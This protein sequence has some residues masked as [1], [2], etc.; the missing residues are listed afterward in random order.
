MGFYGNIT[1]TTRTQFQFDRIYPNRQAMDQM[2]SGDGVY[3]G[4]FVLI[5]YD[6]EESFM[7]PIYLYDGVPYN[8]IP[9]NE[10]EDKFNAGTKIKIYDTPSDTERCIVVDREKFNIKDGDDPTHILYSD[11]AV[12]VPAGMRI[13]SQNQTARYLRFTDSDFIGYENSEVIKYV[14]TLDLIKSYLLEKGEVTEE[15]WPEAELEWKERLRIYLLNGKVVFNNLEIFNIA[16][17]DPEFPLNDVVWEIQAG[18]EYTTNQYNIYYK[19][20]VNANEVTENGTYE[21]FTFVAISGEDELEGPFV[22]NFNIDK[23][24]Y[25]T[26]RGYDS[27]VW[28]KTFVDGIEKY[29]MVAELNTVVPTFDI[30]NDAPTL[31]P[32]TPHFDGASTNVYYRLHWQPSWAMRMKAANKHHRGQT[33]NSRGEFSESGV[34]NLTEDTVIYPSDESTIWKGTFYN[35]INDKVSNLYYNYHKNLW[36]EPEFDKDGNILDYSL[37]AAIYYNRDGFNSEK[38]FESSFLCDEENPYCNSAIKES[39][40]QPNEDKLGFFPT[41]KSGYMYN[42]HTYS[43]EGSPQVDTQEFVMMLPSLGNT[44]SSIWDLIFGGRNTNKTIE[45]SFMRNT[46]IYWEDGK[47]VPKR[48]GLR[49]AGY[50]NGYN[51]TEVNTIAG[52]INS[53]HDLMGMIITS[54]ST[55]EN[56]EASMDSLSMDRIY[57]VQEGPEAGNYFRKKKSYKYT[58][59]PHENIELGNADKI[60]SSVGSL[61]DFKKTYLDSG[62]NVYYQD[63]NSRVE[64]FGLDPTKFDYIEEVKYQPNQIYFNL[65]EGNIEGF[66]D[67]NAFIPNFYF[68]MRDDE[69]NILKLD[70]ASKP[71]VDE[72]DESRFIRKTYYKLNDTNKYGSIGTFD[73]YYYFFKMS[74]AYP[75]EIN[76]EVSWTNPDNPFGEYVHGIYKPNTYFYKQG[77]SYIMDTNLS[78]QNHDYYTINFSDGEKEPDETPSY[79]LKINYEQAPII[80]NEDGTIN[81]YASGIYYYTLAESNVTLEQIEA[82]QVDESLMILAT[83]RYEDLKNNEAIAKFTKDEKSFFLFKRNLSYEENTIVSYDVVAK[84]IKLKEFI[85]NSIFIPQ[86]D[87]S[88]GQVLTGFKF[89]TKEEIPVTKWVTDESGG[90]RLGIFAPPREVVGDNGETT[91]VEEEYVDEKALYLL[92]LTKI[93]DAAASNTR[94]VS[95]R[96]IREGSLTIGDDKQPY[97]LVRELGTFFESGTYHYHPS[98]TVNQND[99]FFL[100][101]GFVKQQSFDEE[102][103]VAEDIVYYNIEMQDISLTP[104]TFTYQ[105]IGNFDKSKTEA[106][107]YG[108]YYCINI[109]EADDNK[110]IFKPVISALKDIEGNTPIYVVAPKKN[111]FYEP[112]QYYV[113]NPDGTYYLS[114]SEYMPT[115]V[116]EN[117]NPVEIVFYK[118][119]GYYVMEDSN[120]YY[121]PGAEWNVL[122][123]EIYP[124]VK[125]GTREE[126]YVLEKIRSLARVDDTMHGL[127]LRINQLLETYDNDT[128]DITTVKGCVNQLN[129]I[130]A[131]FD[132]MKSGNFVLVDEYGRM[133]SAGWTTKQS[134][135]TTNEQISQ[136]DVNAENTDIEEKENRWIS[137]STTPDYD[138]P[139][140]TITHNYNPVNNTET[141]SD[142]NGEAEIEETK[143]GNNNGLRDTIDVYTPIVDSTGHIVGKNTE[144]I[145]LPYG[146]KHYKTAG[147]VDTADADIYTEVTI[148]ESGANTSE[149]VGVEESEIQADN[150]QDE[151]TVTPVNK[152]I[153]T[154]FEEDTLKIAHEIHAVNTEAQETDLN[155]SANK[156]FKVHDLEFD[157]AGHITKNQEH[158]YEMPYGFKNINV[159][160]YNDSSAALAAPQ[161]ANPVTIAADSHVDT[162]YLSSGNHWIQVIPTTESDS[163]RISHTAPSSSVTIYGDATDQNPNFGDSFKTIRVSKDSTGHIYQA[164]ANTVTLPKPSLENGTGNIVTGLTLTPETGA[165]VETK[166]DVGTLPITGF[167]PTVAAGTLQ[168]TDSINTALAKLQSRINDLDVTDTAV[169]GQYISA[170]TQTDGKITISRAD[171]PTASTMA[172]GASEI[173]NIG[174]SGLQIKINDEETV[175]LGSIRLET[176][177]TLIYVINSMIDRINELEEIIAKIHTV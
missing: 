106:D 70:T 84:H 83:G 17:A 42:D 150:T 137:L 116:D 140:F 35:T 93:S 61:I 7:R 52:A 101:T 147:A 78:M 56:L 23:N 134:F 135:N 170:I 49:L 60:Y 117:G 162:L 153:Q 30:I 160:R 105:Y 3:P 75:E 32:L 77:N 9:T 34:T 111:T 142:M 118:K 41:G 58:E 138:K 102:T 82:G 133:H 98:N 130:I 81:G 21:N 8:S 91:I 54:S 20:S 66:T 127:I 65:D 104:G 18:D 125:L 103:G 89:L 148:V 167:D 2:V 16:D 157:A 48:K 108:K 19:I 71:N 40:W 31:L 69:P 6:R 164:R 68:S 99:S 11:E 124:G 87:N 166:A 45:N 113:K 149:T 123:D 95:M 33:I 129:D 141:V 177:P 29:V 120:G 114:R 171:L 121:T 112:N 156:T 144:I 38:I 39:G 132:E 151:L 64:A 146:Y 46:D 161:E 136:A 109:D 128:R 169:A 92:G 72:V 59:V 163:I 119:T 152:W 94:L 96:D 155:G 26:S 1:N 67:L 55:K 44:M 154:K 143:V 62:Q 90:L 76:G 85:E 115:K 15:T 107:Y 27:T 28:Q 53:V 126:I 50:A 22:R 12:S 86:F 172:F 175:M 110:K 100:D 14:G 36:E 25:H 168:V 145:T 173:N 73:N 97:H 63:Y 5:E 13:T 51:T 158:T 159:T 165:F 24:E 174:Q 139:Y 176:N 47:A 74:T 79:I 43:L 80:E 88:L 122:S 57:Y 4:R 37:P 131:R 10:F